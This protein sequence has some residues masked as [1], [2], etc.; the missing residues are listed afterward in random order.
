MLKVNNWENN[1]LAIVTHLLS[2]YV[3][4]LQ[5][6]SFKEVVDGFETSV[7]SHKL[8]RVVMVPTYNIT[9]R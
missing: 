1:Y 8:K 4:I 3:Q 5:G 2:Q 9:F 6:E 7:A